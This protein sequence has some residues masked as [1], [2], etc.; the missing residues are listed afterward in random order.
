[1]PSRERICV[2]LNHEL[3]DMLPIDLGAM[4]STGI[5]AMAYNCLLKKLGLNDRRAKVYDV[6]QQLAKPDLDVLA[7]MGGDVVQ[8][9]RLT[10]AFDIPIDKWKEW[11]LQ[12]GSP[13]LFPKTYDP[14]ENVKGYDICDKATLVAFGGNVFEQG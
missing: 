12:D 3:S 4:R 10:L 9:H 5:N 2:A 14:V 1:M 13:G 6:F 8:A 11:T 7:R